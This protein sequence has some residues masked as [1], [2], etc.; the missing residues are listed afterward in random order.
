[1]IVRTL[2]AYK[3]SSFGYQM[4]AGTTPT[5]Y[6]SGKSFAQ[7]RAKIVWCSLQPQTSKKGRIEITQDASGQSFC[8]KQPRLDWDMTLQ[9]VD[10]MAIHSGHQY[11]DYPNITVVVSVGEGLKR[12][13]K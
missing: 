3:K 7:T 8:W 5:F 12:T 2:R 4:A 6:R 9:K 11:F 1:M 10:A 13:A